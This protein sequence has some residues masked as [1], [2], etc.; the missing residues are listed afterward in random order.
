[1]TE[2]L[3]GR[4]I[5]ITEVELIQLMDENTSGNNQGSNS[6]PNRKVCV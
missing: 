4:Y 3:L 6:V 2:Y 5:P 1:M